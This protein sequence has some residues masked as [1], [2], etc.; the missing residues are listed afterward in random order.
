[1]PVRRK[2]HVIAAGKVFGL[3]SFDFLIPVLHSLFTFLNELVVLVETPILRQNCGAA[4]N[5]R[6]S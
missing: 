4:N 1:M 6:L 5:K 3:L 2:C